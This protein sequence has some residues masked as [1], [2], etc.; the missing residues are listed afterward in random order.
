MDS[1]TTA[2]S[3]CRS[4]MRGSTGWS[5]KLSSNLATGF[6]ATGR[7]H[8]ADRIRSVDPMALIDSGRL[9]R[10]AHHHLGE[11]SHWMLGYQVGIGYDHAS[12]VVKGYGS[13]SFDEM[14]ARSVRNDAR[15]ANA[16]IE[17]LS[18]VQQLSI[19]NVYLND[20]ARFRG[21]P[22]EIFVDAA[23][24]FWDLARRRGLS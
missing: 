14:L 11:W 21:D 6:I 8:V 7:R 5:A 4:T 13:D 23:A 24:A 20:V 1:T 2:F 9:D 15:V 10:G 3:W 19:R 22:V 12:V 17:S 16:V 18:L